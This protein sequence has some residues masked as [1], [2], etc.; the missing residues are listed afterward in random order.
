MA[1]VEFEPGHKEVL[2]EML[3]G[4]PLVRAGKMFGYPAYYVGKK[5]AICLYEGGIGLKLPQASA[6]R[7]LATDP[8]VT[9]FE[10]RGKKMREWV[11]IDLADSAGYRAYTGVLDESIAYIAAAQ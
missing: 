1:A 7:L 6:E 3:L 8:N 10:P 5:L 11:R 9:P 4:N 2:D